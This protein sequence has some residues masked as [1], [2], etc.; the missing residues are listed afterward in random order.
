MREQLLSPVS[1]FPSISHPHGIEMPTFC[2][3]SQ[4][5]CALFFLFSI[6]REETWDGDGTLKRKIN[7]QRS[8][9]NQNWNNILQIVRGQRLE[10][11]TH[12]VAFSPSS[13][14]IKQQWWLG[15]ASKSQL[16]GAW[17]TTSVAA[18]H[19]WPGGSWAEDTRPNKKP[20]GSH[21]RWE[22]TTETA[23]LCI[24]WWG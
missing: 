17:K 19:G 14:E 18:K 6:L 16:C 11:S 20:M 24:S 22:I 1:S 7:S 2:S 3:S 15:Q 12:A 9:Q 5:P 8:S 4:T 13:W 21:I 10:H 23:L